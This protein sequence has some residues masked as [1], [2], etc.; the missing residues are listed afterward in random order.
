[1]IYRDWSFRPIGREKVNTHHG[2]A[3][4]TKIKSRGHG[5]GT[6]GKNTLGQFAIPDFQFE[7]QMEKDNIQ[8][9]SASLACIRLAR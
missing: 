8:I 2:G 6:K 4:K 9:L 3:E 1:M 5:A 7:N